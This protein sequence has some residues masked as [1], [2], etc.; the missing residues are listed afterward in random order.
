MK[1][2]LILLTFFVAVSGVA[3]A[4]DGVRMNEEQVDDL[5]RTI[6]RLENSKFSPEVRPRSKKEIEEAIFKRPYL[7]K[8]ALDKPKEMSAESVAEKRAR[9]AKAVNEAIRLRE[10]NGGPKAEPL[11]TSTAGM[12]N[13]DTREAIAGQLI[14]D[15]ERERAAAREKKRE[16][17]LQRAARKKKEKQK[18]ARYEIRRAAKNK[19]TSARKP[20]F[21]FLKGKA[22]RDAQ[23]E[24]LREQQE[25]KLGVG[26]PSD[27]AVAGSVAI[28]D[29]VVVADDA[30]SW[31]LARS[32]KD[33]KEFRKITTQP[34]TTKQNTL[35]ASNDE[36]HAQGASSA[37]E[38]KQDT[39]E[40]PKDEN[41]AQT[42]KPA[43]ETNEWSAGKLTGVGAAGLGMAFLLVAKEITNPIARERFT[44]AARKLVSGPQRTKMTMADT[45]ALARGFVAAGLT[46]ASAWMLI[47]AVS[48][49]SK[50]RN[51]G[52]S[53]RTE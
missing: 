46:A 37:G 32:R 4:A 53:A 25:A 26:R 28:L 9:I 8:R 18:E 43:G 12:E 50:N 19:P 1:K 42:G 41:P 10:A 21:V 40:A 23:M 44:N 7:G 47:K 39:L 16:L 45:K 35:G 49:A 2:K 30:G 24:F 11:G 31:E 6:D 52:A 22:L 51:G 20:V 33:L 27:P 15:D 36:N 34:S 3:G 14:A 48:R 38:I 17:A 29:D 5:I 13:Q